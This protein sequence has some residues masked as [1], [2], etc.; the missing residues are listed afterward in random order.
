MTCDVKFVALSEI[1]R[2]GILKRQITCSSE[3]LAAV[4]AVIAVIAVLSFTG[5][6]TRYFVRSHV[7]VITKRLYRSRFAELDP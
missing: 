2:D 5:I 6:A 1:N 3:Q 4:I 7:I